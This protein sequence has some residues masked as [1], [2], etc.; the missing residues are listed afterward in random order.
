MRITCQL[1]MTD[2]AVQKESA[3]RTKEPHL[4]GKDVDDASRTGIAS[5]PT[6]NGHLSFPCHHRRSAKSHAFFGNTAESGKTFGFG[7]L[8]TIA[9]DPKHD[10]LTR[11][12]NSLSAGAY[13][14]L[15]PP[16]HRLPSTSPKWQLEG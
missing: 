2:F 8:I 13:Y 10:R 1:L 6:P 16:T 15:L 14:T 11:T 3:D 7:E 9:N 12:T 4:T 5:P